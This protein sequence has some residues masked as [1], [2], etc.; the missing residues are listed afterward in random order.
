[1]PPSI[2]RQAFDGGHLS[3]LALRRKR[4]ARQNALAV[5]QHRAGTARALVAALL[6]TRQVEL[7]AQH[8]EERDAA[9]EPQPPRAPVDDQGHLNVGRRGRYLIHY[10]FRSSR[11]P[12]LP[13]LLFS[14]TGSANAS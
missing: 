2:G 10:G 14:L 5:K 6:R 4:E 7:V 11:G 12:V 13:R 3:A 9:V 8:I 1:M